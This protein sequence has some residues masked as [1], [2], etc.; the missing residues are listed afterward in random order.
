MQVTGWSVTERRLYRTLKRLADS[1][2]LSVRKVDMARTGAKSHDFE[3][4]PLGHNYLCN[5]EQELL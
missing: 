5:I 3:L 2:A 1:G 4:A